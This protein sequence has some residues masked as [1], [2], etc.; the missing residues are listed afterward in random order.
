MKLFWKIFIAVYISFMVSIIFIFILLGYRQIKDAQRIITKDYSIL[1]NIACEEIN[2][3]FRDTGWPFEYLRK[4]LQ[5]EGVLFWWVVQENGNIYLADKASF[6][7]NSAYSYFPLLR[8]KDSLQEVILNEPANYGI[9]L[10]P[11]QLRNRDWT[12]W[13]GFSLSGIHTVRK[14]I[15]LTMLV[16]SVVS[17]IVLGAFLYLLINHFLQSIQEMARGA[18]IIGKGGL[19]HRVE[20]RSED[21]LGQLARVFN[22]MAE[23]LQNDTI[24]RQKAEMELKKSQENYR[25]F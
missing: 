22:E 6:I 1:G 8:E 14:Q 5:S 11:L 24:K 17:L 4:L 3:E 12:F 13:L 7:G 18:A 23:D 25:S 21:E 10:R 9:F 20:V 2:R 16:I 15:I 19:D